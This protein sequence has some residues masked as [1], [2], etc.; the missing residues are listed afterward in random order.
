MD[1]IKDILNKFD[2]LTDKPSGRI[3][4]EY[5][6]FG[7]HLATKLGDQKNKSM[8][9]KFA[10]TIPRPVLEAAY[11]FVVDANAKNKAALFIWK[12]KDLGMFKPNPKVPKPSKKGKTGKKKSASSS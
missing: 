8:Y 10:K 2:P 12:L 11:R 5:Q 1:S 3:S 6:S 4:Q 9:I 7:V